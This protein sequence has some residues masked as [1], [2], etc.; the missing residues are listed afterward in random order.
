MPRAA[1]DEARY[2]GTFTSSDV[3]RVEDAPDLILGPE[4][5][6]YPSVGAYARAID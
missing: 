1:F 5:R 4:L 3:Q 2:F 6:E